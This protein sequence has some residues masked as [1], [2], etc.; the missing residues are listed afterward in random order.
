MLTISPLLEREGKG[1]SFLACRNK[2][3]LAFA[4]IGFEVMESFENQKNV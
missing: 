4:T 1:D 3:Y 2:S